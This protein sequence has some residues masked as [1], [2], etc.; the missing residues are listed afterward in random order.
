MTRG[1][2]WKYLDRV[3]VRKSLSSYLISNHFIVFRVSTELYWH[4]PL[5][6][7]YSSVPWYS[8]TILSPALSS[9][10][11]HSWTQ[12]IGVYYTSTPI[13]YVYTGYLI[14]LFVNDQWWQ[15]RWSNLTYSTF[16]PLLCIRSP[17]FFYPLRRFTKFFGL[18]FVYLVPT[19]QNEQTKTTKRTK[20]HTLLV[21]ESIIPFRKNNSFSNFST[22]YSVI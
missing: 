12:I 16:D 19:T 18:P 17:L 6:P 22:L 4:L 7:F 14:L 2:L 21:G 20:K 10:T 11:V 9:V 13:P 15:P 8:S 1:V 3:V 5:T